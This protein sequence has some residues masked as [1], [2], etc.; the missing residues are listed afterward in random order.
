MLK[1]QQAALDQWEPTGG[2][3]LR[4]EWPEVGPRAIPGGHTN[5]GGRVDER[6]SQVLRKSQEERASHSPPPSRVP[7]V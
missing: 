2:P 7:G 3:Q 1:G 4:R 5:R 6:F